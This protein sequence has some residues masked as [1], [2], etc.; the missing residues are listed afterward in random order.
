MTKGLTFVLIALAVALGACSGGRAGTPTPSAEDVIRTAEAMARQTR[1]AATPTSGPTPVTPTAAVAITPA[2]PTS[3]VTAT[4]VVTGPVV[5]ANYPVKVRSGPGEEYE[6]VDL[7]LTG[8]MARVVGRYDATS[9]GTWYLLQRIDVGKDGWVWSGAVT[10]A[11]DP[12]LIP[13]VT[14]SD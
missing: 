13:V 5:T 11:G 14:P 9:I 1:E 6:E 7:F 10:L 4:P 2:T 3:A 12:A 8:Q